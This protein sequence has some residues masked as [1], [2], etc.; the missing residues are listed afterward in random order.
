M[1]TWT[2]MLVS[3]VYLLLYTGAVDLFPGLLSLSVCEY[4]VY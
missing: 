3:D 2:G 1:I 4:S